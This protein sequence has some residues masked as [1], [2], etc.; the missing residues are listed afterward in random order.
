[1]NYSEKFRNGYHRKCAKN[2]VLISDFDDTLLYWSK[3][4]ENKGDKYRDEELKHDK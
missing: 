1:M 2:D 4:C 3:N